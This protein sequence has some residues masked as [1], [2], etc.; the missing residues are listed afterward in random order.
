MTARSLW[1]VLKSNASGLVDPSRDAVF[2]GRERHVEM[3]RKDYLPYPQRAI[4]T[5]DHLFIINFHPERGPLGDPLTLDSDKPPT[6]KEVENTTFVTF[7]DDD[8]GLT[9]AWLVEHRNDPKWKPY[10][11]HAY[12]LR[13]REEFYDLKADPDQMKNL[14]AD[15]AYQQQVA[16]LR[17]R[18]MA[19]LERSGDPR[20]KDDGKYFETP[21]LAG[22]LPDE[23]PQP[24]RQR[25]RNNR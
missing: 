4:R 7:P 19:E 15:P 18:L 16:K 21:P 1:P 6:F 12:G 9:K 22:P 13:P 8:A 14:A 24:N 2:T 5:A 25:P 10:F 17:N 23:L 11:D 20:L 3:A